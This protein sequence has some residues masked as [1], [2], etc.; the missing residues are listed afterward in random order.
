MLFQLLGLVV[1]RLSSVISELGVSS[2]TL[3]QVTRRFISPVIVNQGRYDS[4]RGSTFSVPSGI[5]LN[6]GSVGYSLKFSN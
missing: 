3:I 6:A 2:R 5:G 1:L 4:F